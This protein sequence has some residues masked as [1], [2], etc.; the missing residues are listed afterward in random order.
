[1]K[2][3]KQEILLLFIQHHI[4]MLE[5]D[6]G[7]E[8]MK[9]MDEYIQYKI[10]TIPII[11]SVPHDGHIEYNGI[12]KRSSGILGFDKGTI[13]LAK[14]LTN[15]FS[16]ISFERI[17]INHTPTQVVS[18]IRRS[19]IDLNRSPTLGAY[20]EG[21]NIASE[22]FNKYHD[23]IQN[24]ILENISKHDISLLI[25]IHGFESHK[26]PPGFREVDVIFGTDNLKSLYSEK[27]PKSQWNNTIRGKLIRKFLKL[28]VSIA[29]GN[30]WQEEIVL[31]GGYIV[32]KHGASNYHKSKAI[33]IEFSDRLRQHNQDLKNLVLKTLAEKFLDEINLK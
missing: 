31:T 20:Y 23:T 18:K 3:L 30:P 24:L 4:K 11:L 32:Q 5:Y 9:D 2:F 25:D 33:Q 7:M 8:N 29:P 22:I 17:G 26:R 12:P 1:M 27:I 21:S 13:I 10:G 19:Q 28:G 14:E 16:K 6:I 15:W